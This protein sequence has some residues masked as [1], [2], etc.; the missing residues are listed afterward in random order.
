MGNIMKNKLKYC[1]TCR[2][3]LREP[4]YG[5]LPLPDTSNKCCDCGS[6]LQVIDITIEDYFVIFHTSKDV[7][8]IEAMIKLHDEDIIEYESRMSQFRA[9]DP[10]YQEKHGLS[11]QS[12]QESSINVPKCPHCNSTNIKSITTGERIGSITML[13]IFSKKIN[14]SFKCL[15][16]KYTW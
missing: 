4:S 15:D 10:W 1:E 12:L 6:P 11:K 9:N 2:K 8:F 14:K 13:G 7:K 5:Y 3:N 16:C